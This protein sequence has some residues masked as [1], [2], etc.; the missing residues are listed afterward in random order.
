VALALGLA[1]H[2]IAVILRDQGPGW[3]SV[4]FRGNGALVVLPIALVLLVVGE[5]L[6][7][8]RGAWLGTVLM[9]LGLFLGLFVVAGSF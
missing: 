2:E 4:S 8:R 3:D 7:A 1:L 9:P 6:C 5:L